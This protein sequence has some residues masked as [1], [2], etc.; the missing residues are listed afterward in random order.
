MADSVIG[1]DIRKHVHVD[2]RPKNWKGDSQGGDL[3][4]REAEREF[5]RELLFIISIL[6]AW[7]RVS[8]PLMLADWMK[9]QN[10]GRGRWPGARGEGREA[11]QLLSQRR[12]ERGFLVLFGVCL[13]RGW[14]MV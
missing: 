6:G 3:S 5:V 4:L 2:M 12:W 9:G 7:L 1:V 14:G 10:G 8:I 11:E 13:C